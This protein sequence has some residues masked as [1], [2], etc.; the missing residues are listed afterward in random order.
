MRFVSAICAL[1]LVAAGAAAERAW[2]SGT[3][4][5]RTSS[6]AYAVE[7][8]TD[9]ITAESTGETLAAT[10]G[11]DVQ[12]AIEGRTLYVRDAQGTEHALTLLESNPKYSK[13]YAA[14]GSGHFITSV[15][16]GGTQVTLEDGSRWD[17]DERQHFAVAGWQVDD[18]ISI[19]R[20]EGD[21]GFAFEIDNTTQ[22]DG[23]LAN[24]RVR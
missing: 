16:P 9:V 17:I 15:A 14:V 10:P 6:G 20:E 7:T 19:R 1:L 18:L 13:N 3:W 21:P 2:K 22:D 8:A 4:V 11:T 23:S 24:Y 12:F 5:A